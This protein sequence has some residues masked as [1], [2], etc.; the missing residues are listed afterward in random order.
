MNKIDPQETDDSIIGSAERSS[1]TADELVNQH[2]E[3]L[4]SVKDLRDSAKKLVDN[5]ADGNTA[6]NQSTNFCKF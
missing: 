2:T 4:K 1:A 5:K 3:T 6:L